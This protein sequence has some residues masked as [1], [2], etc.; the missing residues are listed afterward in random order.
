MGP[1][2]AALLPERCTVGVGPQ[3]GLLRRLLVDPRPVL[4]E[5]RD[6][7]GPIVGLGPGPMRLAVVG[8]PVALR[9]LFSMPVERFRWGHRFNV[10]E[11]VVG[12][13]S[14]LVSDGADWE[15][16]RGALRSGFT[17]RRLNGWVDAIVQAADARIST[18]LEE[19]GPEP[20]VVDLE[21]FGRALVQEIVVRSLFGARLAA[22]SSEIAGLLRR[23]QDYLE[24]PALR[25]LP[26]PFPVGR[27]AAVRDD[28]RRLREIVAEQIDHLRAHPADDPLDLLGTLVAEGDLSD[29]EISDQVVTLMGAGLDTTSATLSW[30]L[31]CCALAGP[32]LWTR[33]RVEAD[34]VLDGTGP[35][36]AT[37]L[38]RLDLAD[39]AVRETTRL[40]P[41]GSF[42]PRQAVVDMTVGGH[43]IPAGTMVLWSS[44]L[45]G[46][47]PQ[48]WD[49]PLRFDPDRYLDV[50]DDRRTLTELAWVPFGRGPRNCIGFALA[51]MELTLI[52]AR[53]AQRV[54]LGAA[55]TEE[56]RAVGMVINRPEGGATVRIAPAPD[57]GSD[58]T[59]AG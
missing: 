20:T 23:A 56:P 7:H 37:H 18:L 27:R 39:R 17:R 32:E 34:E 50:P 36:D 21:P 31:R 28:L 14:L 33:L 58:V 59:A 6:A 29:D 47:D 57:R 25:Q 52:V 13:T 8:D 46:R 51:Q 15:R 9:E 45:A 54:D 38:A 5:L 11:F 12:P 1:P 40:H 53:L 48:V 35:Y 44:H 49:D 26:H 24:S 22:R 30:M 3:P 10:L 55:T 16:R 4:D 19:T 2:P 41:A 42:T 43:R